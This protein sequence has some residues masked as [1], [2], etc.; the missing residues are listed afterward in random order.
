MD[1]QDKTPTEQLAIEIV[2]A[3][4]NAKL[5]NEKHRAEVSKKVMLGNPTADDWAVWIETA[6]AANGKADRDDPQD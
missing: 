4:I 3:L 5:L 6:T 2:D 1:K